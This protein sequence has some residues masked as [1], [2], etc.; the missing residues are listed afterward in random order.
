M[1]E[2]KKENIK[3]AISYIPLVAIFLYFTEK[4]IS[5][6]YYK[7]IKYWI[8]LFIVY[9]VLNTMLNVLWLW[10]F[11]WLVMIAYF[12]ISIILWLKAYNWEKVDVEILD[13]IS[14]KFDETTGKKK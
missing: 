7:H 11:G 6:E 14:D 2:N 3:Y 12:I 4:N 5:E 1:S 9:A 13:N 10:W 8:T